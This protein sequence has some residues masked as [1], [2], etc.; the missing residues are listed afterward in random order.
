MHRIVTNKKIYSDII[1]PTHKFVV[2]MGSKLHR[3]LLKAYIDDPVLFKTSLAQL[4]HKLLVIF[5]VVMHFLRVDSYRYKN[6]SIFDINKNFGSLISFILCQQ[7]IWTVMMRFDSFYLDERNVY[8]IIDRI[9][10]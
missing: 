3:D 2:K 7:V 6:I 5:F 9:P 4:I 8:Q 1:K 10:P